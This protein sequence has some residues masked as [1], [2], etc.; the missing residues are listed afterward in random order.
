M[1]KANGVVKE[2]SKEE[3][4]ILYRSRCNADARG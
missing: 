4:I 2:L 1:K 3:Q